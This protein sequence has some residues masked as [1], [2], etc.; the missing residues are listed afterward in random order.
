MIKRQHTAP[1][2]Y[3]QCVPPKN[4]VFDMMPVRFLGDFGIENGELAVPSDLEMASCSSRLRMRSSNSLLR[5]VSSCWDSLDST[6]GAPH[7]LGRV[8]LD[9]LVDL[10][11]KPEEG[12]CVL[13]LLGILRTR[14]GIPDD[15]CLVKE[16]GEM[17]SRVRR[18]TVGGIGL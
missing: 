1:C 7:E 3:I 14:F 5:S 16:A 12:A 17:V 11:D 10:G 9:R 4:R 15:D 2:V 6:I 8:V 13:K 18:D